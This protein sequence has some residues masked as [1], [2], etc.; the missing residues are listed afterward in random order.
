MDQERGVSCV[1]CLLAF[2]LGLIRLIAAASFFFGLLL[3]FSSFLAVF[4]FQM[5]LK[6]TLAHE[7]SETKERTGAPDNSTSSRLQTRNQPKLATT[8]LIKEKSGG[9]Y[10]KNR[11]TQVTKHSRATGWQRRIK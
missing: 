3:F 8:S 6:N 5:L 7:G 10:K 11:E 9:K 4:S 2:V 1:S